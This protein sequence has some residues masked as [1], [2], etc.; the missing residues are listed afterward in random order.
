[1]GLLYVVVCCGG[2]EPI[3]YV[4]LEW[5]TGDIGGVENLMC[6]EDFSE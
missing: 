2:V 4:V 6:G 5:S 3:L 1:M